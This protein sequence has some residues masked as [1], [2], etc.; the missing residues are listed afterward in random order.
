LT[1]LFTVKDGL[2][3]INATPESGSSVTS[4]H[5]DEELFVFADVNGDDWFYFEDQTERSSVEQCAKPQ[6]RKERASSTTFTAR[7]ISGSDTT[8]VNFAYKSTPK[9]K[10]LHQDRCNFAGLTPVSPS[11]HDVDGE[12]FRVQS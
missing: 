6:S 9:H 12:R 5:N 1:S 10:V 4:R 7:T 11:S 8:L 3:I 2:I